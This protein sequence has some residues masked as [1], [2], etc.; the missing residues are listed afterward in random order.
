[1]LF[2]DI[3]FINIQ[4]GVSCKWANDTQRFLLEHFD[5]IHGCPSQIYYSALPF[6]PSSS[7]LYKCY[8][9]KSKEVRVV[10]ELQAGWGQCSC[11]V[12]LGSRSYSIS[13]WNTTIAVGLQSGDIII[14]DA[15][16]GSITAILS[17][18]ASEVNSVSFS[19]DGKLLASGADDD[20]VKLWDIQTSGIIK[21]F[22]GHQS[23]VW[24][25]S[26]SANSILASGSGDETVFLW[27]ILTG[28]CHCVIEQQEIVRQVCF[29]PTDPQLLAVRLRN[30]RVSHW[31]MNGHQI[32]PTYGASHIAFS[33]DGKQ[34]ALC[35][36][37][38]IIVQIFETRTAIAKFNVTN[39]IPRY[40]CFSP[41]GKFIAAAVGRTA[42]VWD[43][44]SSGSHPIETF[45]GHTSDITALA[46]YSPSSLISASEDMLVKFWQISALSREPVK[47]SLSPTSS[48][49]DK[50]V[51]TT[52]QAKDGITITSDFDGTV[53]I[54]DISTSLCRA[55]FQTPA[56]G[57]GCRD[58]YFVNDRLIIAWKMGENIHI[59]GASEEKLI[60]T[61]RESEF[62]VEYIRIG[63]DGSIVFCLL[64]YEYIQAWSIMTGEVLSEVG[65]KFVS[66]RR[67]LAIDDSRVWV[68]NSRLEY[69]GWDFGI[70]GSLPIQLCNIPPSKLHSDDTLKWDY[71]QSKVQDVVTGRVVFQLPKSLE[72]PIDAQWN[73]QNLFICFGPTRVLILDF[74]QVL[75]L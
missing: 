47:T 57:F 56:T 59:H 68:C 25:V 64:G 5:A 42:C 3:L 75:A 23:H 2:I 46:F 12:A 60:L 24:S 9:T 17:G 52:L 38:A 45:I 22:S 69:Q 7:W 8:T 43:I 10:K 58:V 37:E 49:P 32:G 33:V 13:Y 26:I 63:G 41:N 29:S 62:G 51:S 21:E 54:W 34:F 14:L 71:I 27:D 30:D 20:I 16:T 48:P 6:C 40:C 50:I 44:A 70:P 66:P 19:S 18:H 55:S 35:E 67:L 73:D 31:D 28:E 15:M 61:P 11:T 53:K 72:K 4:V 74:A 36:K 65:I 39:G 1:M